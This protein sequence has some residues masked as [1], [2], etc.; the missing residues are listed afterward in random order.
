MKQLAVIVAGVLM[1]LFG[2]I[3]IFSAWSY[4]VFWSVIPLGGRILSIGSIVIGYFLIFVVGKKV[5]DSDAR[6]DSGDNEDLLDK[7]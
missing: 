7:F 5:E 6:K 4:N 2:G 3:Y 1:I